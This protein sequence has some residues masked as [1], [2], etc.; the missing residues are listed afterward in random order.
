MVRDLL[1]AFVHEDWVVDLDFA[2]LERVNSQFITKRLKKRES[3]VIWRVRRRRGDQ[4]EWLYL[5]LLLEFQS[6]PSRWMAL[7]MWVYVGLLYQQL[8]KEKEFRGK[9]LPPVLPLVL[10]NGIKSWHG[11]QEVAEL[12]EPAPGD[13][14]RYQPR[15]RYLLLDESKLTDA[16]EPA[17]AGNMA[18]LLVY[19]EN[20]QVP[21]ALRPG[22]QLLIR[23]LGAPEQAELRENFRDWLLE[24]KL[25][26][27]LAGSEIPDNIK[28]L[29]EVDAMLAERVKQWTEELTRQGRVEGRAEGEIKGRAEGRAEGEVKGRI[30]ERGEFLRRQAIRKFGPLAAEHQRR[31]EEATPGQLLEWG[32]RILFATTPEEMFGAE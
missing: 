25:P 17:T 31:L 15:M 26:A 20:T 28:Q 5:Y 12:I 29:E 6:Q 21:E 24:V 4:S 14:G 32:E 8:A 16:L 2:T 13:L 3:D 9:R 1:L 11:V 10:Y 7:R 19:L 22:I 27:Q 23:W 18:A 30:A